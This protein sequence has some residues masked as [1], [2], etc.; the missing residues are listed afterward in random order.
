MARKGGGRQ[1][2]FLSVVETSFSVLF[3]YQILVSLNVTSC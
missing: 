2:I 1:Q 3:C